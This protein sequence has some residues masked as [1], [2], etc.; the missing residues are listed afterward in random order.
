MMLACSCSISS[1]TTASENSIS[2]SNSVSSV[3]FSTD[4]GVM[5]QVQKDAIKYFWDFAETN[6]KLARE[7]YHTDNPNFDANKVTIGGSGFGLM[8][9]IVGVERGF[10][11]R[12]EAVSR[13]NIAMEFL[14]KADR[15]HGAWPHWLDGTTGHTILFSIE[16]NGGDIVETAFLCQGLLALREYFKNGNIEEKSIAV[17]ADNLWRGVEWSWYTKGENV[18]YWHWSPTYNWEKNLKIQGYNE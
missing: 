13:M 8:S 6:S 17:R 11:P 7:R 15:F 9:I 5:N 4:I 14:E 10:I 2:S 16:D 3:P 12:S 1:D 18:L